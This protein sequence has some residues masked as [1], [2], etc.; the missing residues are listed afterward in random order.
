[1]VRIIN[2]LPNRLQPLVRFLAETGCRVGEAINLTWDCVDEING[3]V[4]ITSQD[5]WTPKTLQSERTI[6]LNT[7]LLEMIRSLPKTSHYVFPT[8]NADAPIKDFSKAFRSAVAQAKITRNGKPVHVTAK[9]LRKAHATWQAERGIQESV[10]QGLLGHA[11]GSKITKQFYI[12]T[13]EK[14]KKAAVITLPFK[15]DKGT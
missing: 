14:A 7:A 10:L 2:A 13:T 15:A 6:P 3:S 5:G 12:H 1:M 4:E 11:R 8:H 9:T